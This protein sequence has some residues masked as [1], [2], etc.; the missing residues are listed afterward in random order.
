MCRPAST[1]GWSPPAPT[2][3][4]R[5]SPGHG[6]PLDSRPPVGKFE[7]GPI[8]TIAILYLS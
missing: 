7:T 4:P 8:G 6:G 5:A 2:C 1:R 3:P